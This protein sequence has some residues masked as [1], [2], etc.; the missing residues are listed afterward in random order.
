M[1]M[2]EGCVHFSLSLDFDNEN[3][4]QVFTS[5]KSYYNDAHFQ[6]VSHGRH[7]SLSYTEVVQHNS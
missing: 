4:F 7:I 2:A 1:P 6:A 3:I 5:S